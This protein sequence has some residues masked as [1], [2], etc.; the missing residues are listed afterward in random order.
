MIASETTW[1]SNDRD[2][3]LMSE[4]KDMSKDVKI[5]PLQESISQHKIAKDFYHHLVKKMKNSNEII[6]FE[7][8][9]RKHNFK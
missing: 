8:L 1:L 5:K 6:E 2:T 3:N 7:C 4:F 9:V